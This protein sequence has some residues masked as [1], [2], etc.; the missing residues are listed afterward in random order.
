MA[1]S[2]QVTETAPL[3][4]W[5]PSITVGSVGLSGE[6]MASDRGEGS[7]T[8]PI[9]N[10]LKRLATQEFDLVAVG[11]ALL[12]DPEWLQKVGRG[13]FDKLRAYDPAAMKILS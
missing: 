3:G 10:L 9:D 1:P 6:F 8:Q 11:R 12:D 13:E 5:R 4:E 7:K 2:Q